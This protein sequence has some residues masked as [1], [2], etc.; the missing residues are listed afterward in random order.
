MNSDVIYTGEILACPFCGRAPAFQNSG[1]DGSGKP[2]KFSIGCVSLRACPTEPYTRYYPSREEAIAAWNTRT[3]DAH[4]NSIDLSS[5]QMHT[6]Q[7]RSGSVSIS[8]PSVA[9]DSSD[10]DPTG[11]H[12]S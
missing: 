12:D 5:P 10:A 6:D 1:F 3:P 4:A 2:R 7:H 11:G 9:K 8:A